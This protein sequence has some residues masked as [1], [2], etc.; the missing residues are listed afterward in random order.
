MK[1][2]IL[3]ALL[4]VP[5]LTFSQMTGIT[6]QQLTNSE[7]GNLRAIKTISAAGE[8]LNPFLYSDW[9]KGYVKL[10]DSVVYNQDK[11]HF[12]LES[13]NVTLESESGNKNE[14]FEL[15]P[16]K[17]ISFGIREKDT[18]KTRVF[19]KFNSSD[20][21]NKKEGSVN[22]FEVISS[23]RKSEPVLIHKIY[24]KEVQIKANNS[25]SG[26]YGGA[27]AAPTSG[28]KLKKYEYFYFK[29]KNG[30]FEK[31]K[32][33]NK[34]VLKKFNDKKYALKT[35]IKENNLNCKKPFHAAQVIEYYYSL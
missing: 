29:N 19:Q 11:I 18:E 30:K 27:S 33:S 12:N 8:Q 2:L 28:S 26:G 9:S 16:S 13:N 15:S 32:L 1:K 21:Q 14:Y 35:F 24:K 34:R 31:I 25:G 23:S 4:F 5:V 3:L 17:I 20:F 22:F 10:T 7:T 6:N